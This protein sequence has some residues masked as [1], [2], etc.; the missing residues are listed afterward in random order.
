MVQKF[1]EGT[2]TDE[3]NDASEM[4]RECVKAILNNFRWAVSMC[5]HYG[6]CRVYSTK[7]I[8]S[9]NITLTQQDS[10]ETRRRDPKADLGLGK[11]WEDTLELKSELNLAGICISFK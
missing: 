5:W 4:T 3:N 8:L 10:W 7:S 2:E 11:I 6:R 9:E 1:S